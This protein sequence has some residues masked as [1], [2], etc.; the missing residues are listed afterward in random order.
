VIVLAGL[1]LAV[2]LGDL[3]SSLSGR[4][5]SRSRAVAGTV[6]GSAAAILLF[7]LADIGWDRVAAGSI[8]I[9]LTVTVWQ[10][11]RCMDGAWTPRGALPTL[12]A[13]VVPLALA[14]AAS[15]WFPAAQG[16]VARVVPRM[17]YAVVGDDPDHL[18]LVLAF[19]LLMGSTGNAVVRLALAGVGTPVAVG[20]ARLRG[21]RLIGPLERVLIFGLA[22]AGQPT[23]AALVISA[24]GLLRFPE[25]NDLRGRS[26]DA[27]GS[28][29]RRIDEVT[30]Y[31]LVGSLM[32]WIVALAP[33]PLL[34]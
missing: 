21:G 5:E 11:A 2:G 14:I 16:T 8:L 10:G 25:L 28:G 30:E 13:L 32:S 29:S 27:S 17:P 4:P 20:E 1:V 19:L 9:A 23:A 26:D 3:V 34:A 33:L 31:L 18:L 6:A 22:L 7:V 15:A 24:K 12:A